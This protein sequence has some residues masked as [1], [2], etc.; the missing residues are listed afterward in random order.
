MRQFSVLTFLLSIL[1]AKGQAQSDSVKA[2]EQWCLQTSEQIRTAFPSIS[3]S[4]I[5]FTNNKSYRVLSF[6][7]TSELESAIYGDWSLVFKDKKV[8][9]LASAINESSDSAHYYFDGL[10]VRF[11]ISDTTVTP[12]TPKDGCWTRTEWDYKIAIFPLKIYHHDKLVA[13]SSDG[14]TYTPVSRESLNEVQFAQIVY[15]LSTERDFELYYRAF[16]DLSY[17]RGNY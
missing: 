16:E 4:E 6:N 12:K 17:G 1:L 3:L 5:A 8:Y 13:I 15:A 7:Y 10:E 2:V 9:R 14:K 11:V